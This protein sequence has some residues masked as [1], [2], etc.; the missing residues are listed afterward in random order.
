MLVEPIIPSPEDTK[1]YLDSEFTRYAECPY[2]N[3]D[4]FCSKDC[5]FF[6][7][8]YGEAEDNFCTISANNSNGIVR[9]LYLKK[10]ETNE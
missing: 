3:V 10:E 2:N 9:L 4:G 5:V 1:V 7:E 6:I 8:K